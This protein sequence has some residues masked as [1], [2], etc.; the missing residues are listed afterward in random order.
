MSFC[1]LRSVSEFRMYEIEFILRAFL[2]S[3]VLKCKVLSF[4]GYH[5]YYWRCLFIK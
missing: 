1:G 3:V 5:S 4:D 2:N